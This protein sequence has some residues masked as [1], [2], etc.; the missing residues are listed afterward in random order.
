MVWSAPPDSLC[1]TSW[2]FLRGQ[3][4][5]WFSSA[6]RKILASFPHSRRRGS[7]SLFREFGSVIYVLSIMSNS[8]RNTS[9]TSLKKKGVF[10]DM[11][12]FYLSEQQ[13]KNTGAADLL[14]TPFTW[15]VQIS[16]A[17]WSR[18]WNGASKL[19]QKRK[20]KIKILL[21]IFQLSFLDTVSGEGDARKNKITLISKVSEAE[22]L[23]LATSSISVFCSIS[24]PSRFLTCWGCLCKF[25]SSFPWS[26]YWEAYFWGTVISVSWECG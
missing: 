12:E 8:V 4:L 13:G 7:L 2:T 23:S 26:F 18:A 21:D 15:S 14:S 22:S 17:W 1:L 19:W 5:R 20:R 24:P 10:I 11:I 25:S 6:A 9:L 16:S 3:R